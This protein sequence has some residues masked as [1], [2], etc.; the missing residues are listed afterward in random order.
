MTT[1]PVRRRPGGRS[2][3]VRSAVTAAT[4]E[5]LAESGP[6]KLSIAEV[7]AR[8]GVHETSV[9]RRWR[10]RERLVLD[11]MIEL[12]N[13]LLAVPD[14]GSLRGDLVALG[15]KIVGYGT[16][17][18]GSALVRSLAAHEDD[19]DTARTRDEFWENRLTGAEVMMERAKA[20][21]ELPAH[22]DSRTLLELFVSPI[23]FRLLLTRQ[24]VDGRYLERIAAITVAGAAAT[25]P[26][27]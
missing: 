14:T 26:H 21:G 19:A 8:A 24:P 20:R 12:S 5:L 3:K 11:S 6:D 2:A 23:H 15:Q 25:P 27:C 17:P 13:E 9:Y 10:T 22:V 1:D 18:L 7:A 16:S 4:L